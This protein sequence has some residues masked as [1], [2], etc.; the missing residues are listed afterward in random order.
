M[1][2]EWQ[3]NRIRCAGF[4]SAARRFLLFMSVAALLASF[5]VS[6][7]IISEEK[8]ELTL[9]LIFGD[10]P[11][12]K[13]TI[14]TLKW[15]PDSRGCSYIET[16][17]EKGDDEEEIPKGKLMFFGLADLK[18]FVLLTEDAL[19]NHFS[20]LTEKKDGEDGEKIQ[21][22]GLAG[23]IWSP[24]SDALLFPSEKGLFL[25]VL[26]EDTMKRIGGEGSAE[27]P[28]FSPDG[29]FI[30]FIRNH[31]LFVVETEGGK[32]WQ[33]T[34]D[35]EESLLYGRLD[36]VHVEEFGMT[37]G[38]FWGPESDRLAFYRVDERDVKRYPITHF[39]P[40]YPE[41]TFQGYPRPGYSNADVRIGIAFPGQKKV[42]WIDLENVRGD[43]YPLIVWTSE[44]RLMM[45]TMNREQNRNR[46]LLVDTDTDITKM[47]FEEKDNHW[48]D[49]YDDL[50]AFRESAHFLRR[51]A[52]DGW[53]HIYLHDMESGSRRQL[54]KGKWE[55]SGISHVDEPG[56]TIYFMATT[57]GPDERHLYRISTDGTGVRS[58]TTE[59]GTHAVKF[60]PDGA[61]FTDIYSSYLLPVT[62]R[63]RDREGKEVARIS[64]ESGNPAEIYG[65]EAPEK[66]TLRGRDG[67]FLHAS[68]LKPPD[69]DPAGKYPVL[70][71]VYAGPGAQVVRNY[72]RGTIGLWEQMMAR[73]GYIIFKVDGRGSASRGR[74]FSRQVYG[75][76]GEKE[77]EDQ[78]AGVDYLRSLPFVDSGRI[79]IWGWSYGGYMTLNGLFNAPG[80]F[81]AGIAVAPVTDW[82]YYDTIYTERYMRLPED[83]P[84]GY[85][86]RSLLD[87]CGQLES[88]LLLVHG[89]ADHNVHFQHTAVLVDALITAQKQ[90]SLMV[91]P[92]R[93]HGIRDRDARKHLFTMITR[94]IVENI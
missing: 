36:W 10:A 54:T 16:V 81:C 64:S 75:Q 62:V 31:N 28:G 78:L 22:P 85:E 34:E 66:L 79:G 15:R 57:K 48:F 87:K 23:Y 24:R 20:R 40:E 56:K 17:N 33:I 18:K 19:E 86:S 49:F 26:E 65:L 77:L 29:R 41:V 42:Q 47:L 6:P 89:L 55:V 45:Q 21:P 44:S 63:I 76:L 12:G 61:Y 46:F 69:F 1:T 37:D 43:Y 94:F 72:W 14:S 91:Y 51:S 73:M 11:P 74:K 30:A 90:F 83:N 39:N 59:A 82:R 2:E 53:T 4:L 50:Y 60:S 13:S 32:E 58:L 35:G 38:F 80:V 25:Y 52:Q 9:D 8:K 3:Y 27:S 70:I 68:I 71:Y 84:G 5:P 92:G 67:Q 88:K 93:S 7:E